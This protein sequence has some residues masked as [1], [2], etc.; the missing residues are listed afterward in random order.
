LSATIPAPPFNSTHARRRVAPTALSSCPTGGSAIRVWHGFRPLQQTANHAHRQIGT[1]C[2][3]CGHA[4][5]CAT[6]CLAR[7]ANLQTIVL[8][9]MSAISH[10]LDGTSEMAT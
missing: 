2:D 4:A 3:L 5:K 7:A 6:H 1:E 9:E 10:F 8:E